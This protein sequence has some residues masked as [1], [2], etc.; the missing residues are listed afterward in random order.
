MAS[1]EPSKRG[2]FARTHLISAVVGGLIVGA[3]FLVAGVTASQ[4]TETVNVESPVSAQA[5]PNSTSGPT[6]NEIY[7]RYAPAVVFVQATLI[8]PVESSFNLFRAGDSDLS[9]GSG[10]LVDKSGDILTNYHVIDGADRSNGVT[11]EFEGPVYRRA[12]VVAIDQRND[13]AVLHVNMRGVP[14]IRPVKRGDSTSVRVGDPTL[15]IGNP[16]GLDRTLTSGIVSALQHQIKAADGSVINNVIQTDQPITAGN[17][18]APLVDAEGNVI[19][20]NSQVVTA[21]VGA[22]QRL[23]FAVPIDTADELLARVI[24]G[25]AVLQAYLGVGQV[26]PTHTATTGH[27]PASH[28]RAV[29]GSVFKDGPAANAGLVPG[30]TIEKIDG[31]P[32]QSIQDVLNIVSTRSPGQTVAVVIRRGHRQKTLTVTLGSRSAQK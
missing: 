7:Q 22:S 20:I 32:V 14:S 15:T 11:V 23:S 26:V 13:L 12:A 24:P 28:P 31:L 10:F 19:G 29:V 21:G 30:D 25:A 2:M 17:S 1:S 8:E 9:T 5:A 4:P 18:G 6:P 27:K 3:G 16:F